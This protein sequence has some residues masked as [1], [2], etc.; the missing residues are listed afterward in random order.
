MSST[1]LEPLEQWIGDLL[2]RLSDGELKRITRIVGTELR[3]SQAQRIA[4]QENPDGSKY[5][6]RSKKN[7]RGKQGGIRRKSMFTKL[8]TVKHLAN[9]SNSSEITVGFRARSAMIALVHQGG[10]DSESFGSTFK[11]PQ[12]QLLGFKQTELDQ[13]RDAFL[14]FL[15]GQK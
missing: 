10:L 7:F 11:M 9:Q 15:A 2:S 12:R 3:R 4:A 8:R 13:I 5:S 1:D 6:P 14:Q